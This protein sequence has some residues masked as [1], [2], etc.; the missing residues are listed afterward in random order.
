MLINI[1]FVYVNNDENKNISEIHK[2]FF[3]FNL[4]NRHNGI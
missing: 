4:K 2:I 1:I 3:K